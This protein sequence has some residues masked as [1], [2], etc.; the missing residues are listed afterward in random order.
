MLSKNLEIQKKAVPLH[1][2]ISF[3][4]INYVVSMRGP[5]VSGD[6]LFFLFIYTHLWLPETEI[7]TEIPHQRKMHINGKSMLIS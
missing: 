7:H 1:S 5:H 4:V 2:V 3:S 6:N